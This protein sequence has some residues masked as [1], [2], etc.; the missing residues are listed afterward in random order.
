MK[1]TK[2]FD[3]LF[4][5]NTGQTRIEGWVDVFELYNL[6]VFDQRILPAKL[7]N[8]LQQSELQGQLTNVWFSFEPNDIDNL[9]VTAD[10]SNIAMRPVNGI[11]GFSN[12][13]GSFVIGKKNAGLELGGSQ[14]MLDFADQFRAPFEIEIFKL[15][16]YASLIGKDFLM[17]IPSFEVANKDLGVEGRVWMEVNQADKPFLY[18]RA[19]FANAIGSSTSKYVPV[20]LMPKK[21][22]DWVDQGIRA[23]DVAAGDLLYHGRLKHIKT[24]VK[25]RAGELV[26]DF[27]VENAEVMF[28]PK[29]AIARNGAGRVVFHNLGVDVALDTVSYDGIENGSAN[30][31]IADFQ[32]VE[33]KVDVDVDS[34][35]KAAVQT[36]IKTP[37]G[38]KYESISKKLRN[39]KGSVKARIGILLPISDQN[40]ANTVDIKLSFK[41]SAFQAPAWGLDLTAINGELQITEQSL[42]AKAMEANFFGDP[43]VVDIGTDHKNDQTIVQARGHIKSQKMLVLLPDYLKSGF[44]GSS[45]WHVKLGIANNP[46]RNL[47]PIVQINA[48]S[49]LLDTEIL[50]PIPF[51][52]SGQSS[53]PATLQVSI[54]DNDWIDFNLHYGSNIKARGRIK[55]DNRGGYRLHTLGLGFS[56]PIRAKTS[57]GI[58]IYGLL[59]QLPLDEWIDYYQSRI[60]S[61]GARA[62]DLM[63]LMDSIDL[64]VQSASIFGNDLNDLYLNMR[65]SPAGFS[66]DI[67]SSMLKGKIDLPLQ[68]SSTQ[69]IVA[70][71]EYLRLQSSESDSESTGLIPQDLFNLRLH[72]KLLSY[73]DMVFTD[74]Q[75]DTRIDD[76]ELTIDKLAFRHDKVL[77]SSGATWQYT[78]DTK[79]HRSAVNISITGQEL[80]Q[81]MAALGLGDA[82]LN[83]EVNL[84]GQVRWSGELLHLDW[85]SLVGD[86]RLELT[87][88]VLKN[89]DPGSG[90][91][92]GLMSLSALPRRLSLDF[93]DV[94]LEGMDFDKITGTYT[95]EGENLYTSNTSMK[96]PSAKVRISGRTGLLAR[97]YDQKLVIIPRI[98]STLPVV[99]ALAVGT[100]V[101]WG[102][103]LL[104]NLFKDV[105]DKSVEVEYRVTGTWD[106]PRLDLVKKIELKKIERNVDK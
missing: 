14:M 77:L 47:G 102:L 59:R 31:S 81:T 54:Y 49:N 82:L 93:K 12:L 15:K 60:V 9:L 25:N 53:R 101:G 72:S 17:S 75:L 88:G 6:S 5:T 55:A 48:N 57:P 58:K 89:V 3:C 16:A 41:N 78:T 62:A 32:H 104:Q 66:A 84:D 91:I 100:S 19:K 10:A 105:I 70:N 71:L 46:A 63:A 56:T 61:G 67:E 45:D 64:E 51:S 97:D 37:V 43:V 8:T 28:D 23:A 90:R 83:G 2:I 20:K 69:P 76:D 4:T 68:H 1:Q 44:Q 40:K 42:M 24:L 73:D 50:F 99:G 87:K 65:R 79:Q 21:A 103:L 38:A 92:V 30:I 86:A 106:D 34:S 11:P 7:A 13:G 95:I 96:G 18:L 80:G 36:W 52:K 27:G 39:I 22:V 26:V 29:W 35:T 98:R 94:L 74:L 33:I 85:E